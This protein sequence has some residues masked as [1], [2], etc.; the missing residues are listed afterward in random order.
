[1]GLYTV[2]KISIINR[3]NN[4]RNLKR[5]LKVIKEVTDY[6]FYINSESY[7]I[8][9][10][11]NSGD[12]TTWYSF[13]EDIYEISQALPKLKILVEARG[14]DGKTWEKTVKG[15]KDSYSDDESS[16]DENNEEDEEVEDSEDNDG[17]EN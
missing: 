14:E 11:C 7:I 3:Y 5:L 16:E 17:D 6:K 2:H 12:G 9:D 10:N 8:D 13:K 1:M 4:L 15:G